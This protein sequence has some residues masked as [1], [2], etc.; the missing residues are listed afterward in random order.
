MARHFDF[1]WL[2]NTIPVSVNLGYD[3]MI[4]VDINNPLKINKHVSYYDIIKEARELRVSTG[5]SSRAK[6]VMTI[7]IDDFR[8]F[9][10][11]PNKEFFDM[12]SFDK[13]IIDVKHGS[14]MVDVTDYRFECRE[15]ILSGNIKV[16]NECFLNVKVLKLY[17]DCSKCVDYTKL[18]PV[19]EH[20]TVSTAHFHDDF[21]E[22]PSSLRYLEVPIVIDESDEYIQETLKIPPNLEKLRWG[23]RLIE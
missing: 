15:L 13:I 21:L 18:S 9:F 2:T 16:T 4:Y 1:L 7:Y 6:I 19:L 8:S 20:L 23:R 12:F 14:K 22:L 11:I 10:E 5:S 3:S 17:N